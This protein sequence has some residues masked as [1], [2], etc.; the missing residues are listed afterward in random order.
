MKKLNISSAIV[1]LVFSVGV[2][3]VDEDALKKLL[4]TNECQKCSLIEANLAD[5]NLKKANLSGANLKGFVAYRSDFTNA[6]LTN[7]NIEEADF[8]EATL[9]NTKTPWGIE[10]SGCK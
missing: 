2:G 1:G 6:D 7:T 8:S 5:A 3:A 9:C 4:E 10:N